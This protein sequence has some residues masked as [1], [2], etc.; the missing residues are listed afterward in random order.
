MELFLQLLRCYRSI[1][2]IYPVFKN[3]KNMYIIFKSRKKHTS[4]YI[5]PSDMDIESS[6]KT[7]AHVCCIWVCVVLEDSTLSPSIKHTHTHM[8]TSTRS[9][10]FWGI[11]M[12]R[13]EFCYNNIVAIWLMTRSP[14]QKEDNN[15]MGSVPSYWYTY[16]ECM[17]SF[18]HI[19][20]SISNI[21]VVVWFQSFTALWDKISI[22]IIY[23]STVK[24]FHFR[25]S[26]IWTLNKWDKSCSRRETPL[27][28][29]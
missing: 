15:R 5:S 4:F 16:I 8:R 18:L 12:K 7:Q 9:V 19:T 2:L 11:F 25:F 17:I 10:L 20:C 29:G 1:W 26:R 27:H 21:N 28:D 14:Q 3:L 24:S 23:Y 22:N 13:L 6:R